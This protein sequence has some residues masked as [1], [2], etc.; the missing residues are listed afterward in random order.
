MTLKAYLYAFSMV[1]WVARGQWCV[2]T[3]VIMLQFYQIAPLVVK[4]SKWPVFE[5][6]THPPVIIFKGVALSKCLWA[7][8]PTDVLIIYP[9]NMWNIPFCTSG[10]SP[11]R[12][13]FE[14]KMFQKESLRANNRWRD[15]S[16]RDLTLLPLRD[17]NVL[18]TNSETRSKTMRCKR[19]DA[20][21]SGR[22]DEK[23]TGQKEHLSEKISRGSQINCL[24]NAT[25]W[26]INPR[27]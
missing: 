22:Q 9:M 24:I 3:F 1:L 23:E 19:E 17:K 5:H 4:K 25:N 21:L 27:K 7:V 12:W 11:R 13:M 10:Y 15:W 20:R 18:R 2:S 16:Y 26:R 6:N 8:S 14:M